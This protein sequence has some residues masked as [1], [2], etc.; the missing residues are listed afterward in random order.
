[1]ET[2]LNGQQLSRLAATKPVLRTDI[3]RLSGR[4]Q[5]LCHRHHDKCWC[6]DYSIVRAHKEKV[7]ETHCRLQQPV[8]SHNLFRT[9]SSLQHDLNAFH[10]AA[11]MASQKLTCRSGLK[12]VVSDD[13]PV[14][15]FWIQLEIDTD[16]CVKLL[17]PPTT[18]NR[19]QGTSYKVRVHPVYDRAGR[20]PAFLA[21]E[22]VLCG[23]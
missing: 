21:S 15:S 23:T 8:L 1:M 16:S 12:R 2:V 22:P 13:P 10:D 18:G 17:S 9:R 5:A 7:R 6:W 4:L 11:N 3:S 20:L 19:E 14:P